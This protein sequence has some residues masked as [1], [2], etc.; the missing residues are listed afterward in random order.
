LFIQKSNSNSPKD[1]PFTE[2]LAKHF[3]TYT[4]QHNLFDW[5]NSHGF[6]QIM[7][8]PYKFDG[9]YINFNQSKRVC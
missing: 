1:S 4:F 3:L 2:M 5:L 9:C 6:H 7:W 8:I